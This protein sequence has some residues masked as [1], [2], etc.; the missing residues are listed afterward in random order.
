MVGITLAHPVCV[1]DEAH[2]VFIELGTLVRIDLMQI[3]YSCTICDCPNLDSITT[4]DWLVK[5]RRF[6]R[7]V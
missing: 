3:L 4:K 5:S 1:D 2:R 7:Q 6:Q